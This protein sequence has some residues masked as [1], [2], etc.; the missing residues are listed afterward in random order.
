M[1][2]PL[3][4]CERIEP[5]RGRMVGAGGCGPTRPGASA[6]ARVPYGHDV[7]VVTEARERQGPRDGIAGA[8]CS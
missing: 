1:G 2:D 5:A 4:L 3:R 7:T 8:I 6:L